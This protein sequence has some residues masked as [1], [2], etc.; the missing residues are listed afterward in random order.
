MTAQEL[1]SEIDSYCTKAGITPATLCVRAIGNS[2]F[3]P[4]LLR[5]IENDARVAEKIRQFI[6]ENPVPETPEGDAA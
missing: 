6:S 3:Y 4:R 1:I 2:R 5:R